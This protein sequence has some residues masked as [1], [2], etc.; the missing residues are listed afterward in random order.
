[1]NEVLHPYLQRYEKPLEVSD[2]SSSL[3]MIFKWKH[4]FNSQTM[5]VAESTYRYLRV[6]DDLVDEHPFANEAKIIMQGE[7][8]S[9]SGETTSGLQKILLEPLGNFT[10][11][12]QRTIREELGMLMSGMM[13]DL[14]VRYIQEPLS[15]EGITQRNYGDIWPALRLGGLIWGG[16]DLRPATETI[17]LMDTLGRYD[18]LA[19]LTEDLTHGLVLIPQEHIERYGFDFQSGEL[20]PNQQLK[21]YYNRERWNITRDLLTN[22]PSIFDIGLPTWIATLMYGYFLRRVCN[23][24]NP[25]QVEE[26]AVYTPPVDSLV[27]AK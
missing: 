14:H 11:D 4:L 9:L 7:L 10:I 27:I 25:L 20:L 26:G 23:L 17:G 5:M 15:S 19:D 3:R 22:A 13:V 6:L 2:K 21:N 12:R 1:M 8:K 16:I 18:N 24:M